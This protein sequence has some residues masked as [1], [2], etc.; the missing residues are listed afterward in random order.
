MLKY[1]ITLNELSDALIKIGSD[2]PN[3]AHSTYNPEIADYEF[4]SKTVY[5]EPWIFS[6]YMPRYKL[7]PKSVVE[8]IH[9]KYGIPKYK[10]KQLL[11]MN[12]DEGK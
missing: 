7:D 10:V 11:N 4:H 6:P 9:D 12:E 2:Y 3:E 8:E 1:S 5:P